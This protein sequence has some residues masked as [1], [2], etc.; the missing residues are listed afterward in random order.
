[1][2]Q[3]EVVHEAKQEVY[4]DFQVSMEVA[5]AMHVPPK[6]VTRLRIPT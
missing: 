4:P 2:V 1:M 6:D 5:K 3:R